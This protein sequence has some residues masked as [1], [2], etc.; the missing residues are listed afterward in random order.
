[1][2]TRDE[3]I[4]RALQVLDCDYLSSFKAANVLVDAGWRPPP[5]GDVVERALRI[6][7]NALEG[8]SI[9]MTET[10][11]IPVQAV[12]R[13]LADASLLAYSKAEV[14]EEEPLEILGMRVRIDDSVPPNVIEF[15]YPAD[16][17]TVE[18]V[19]RAWHDAYPPH[20]YNHALDRPEPMTWEE[21]SPTQRAI[22]RMRAKAAIRALGKGETDG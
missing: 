9:V 19:A 1:M 18:R 14:P 2:S 13:A 3:L 7:V 12:V 22:D 10:W 11:F 4:E 8:Q 16:D 6:G 21:R 17:E 20:R 5:S 15:R